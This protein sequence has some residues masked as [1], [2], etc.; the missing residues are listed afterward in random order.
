MPT[1]TM[2]EYIIKTSPSGRHH[3]RHHHHDSHYH[4]R[5]RCFDSCAGIPV[6][7][8]DGLI[9]QNRDLASSNEVLTRENQ[10]LKSELQTAVQENVRLTTEVSSLR[11]S[12]STDS[13]ASF[14]RR[15]AALT[16]EVGD[17]TA[18]ADSLRRKKEHLATRVDVLSETVS[19]NGRAIGALT[20]ELVDWKRQVAHFRGLYEKYKCMFHARKRDLEESDRL[21][22]EQRAMLRRLEDPLPFRSGRRY[23]CT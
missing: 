15:I 8:W 9:D 21:V 1:R 16:K 4:S 19:E 5:T 18:E 6:E 23:S 10:T 12:R 20:R 22:K 2:F 11:R 7:K 3:H 17:R 13:E 14:R